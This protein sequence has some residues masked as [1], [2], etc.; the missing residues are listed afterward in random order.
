MSIESCRVGGCFSRRHAER[1]G[2]LAERVDG[3]L[4]LHEARVEQRVVRRLDA[5]LADDLAR[6]RVLVGVGLELLLADL[7]EQAEEL[8]AEGAERIAPR[9]LAPTLK[10]GKLRRRAPAGTRARAAV[11]CGDDDGGRERRVEDVGADARRRGS[12]QRRPVSRASRRSSCTPAGL[13]LQIAVRVP[14]AERG[15]VGV[16]HDVSGGAGEQTLRGRRRSRRARRAGRRCGTPACAPPSRTASRAAPG[17]TRR[18]GAAA[19]ARPRRRSPARRSG[20]RSRGCGSTARRRAS[21]AE[22]RRPPGRL[23]GSFSRRRGS[24]LEIATD[25]RP[26]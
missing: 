23:R 17:S 10:P 3:D 24:G 19:R 8:A 13:G 7:A 15:G 22:G 21:T 18:A 6:L 14:G 4:R 20:R 2:D 26:E 5:A 12:P 9:R 11:G 16:D 1:A 25:C